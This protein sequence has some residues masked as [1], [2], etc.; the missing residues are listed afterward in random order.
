MSVQKKGIS[1]YSSRTQT[2]HDINRL[3]DIGLT[4]DQ[5]EPLTYCTQNK[6]RKKNSRY[7]HFNTGKKQY[8]GRRGK[9]TSTYTQKALNV[10]TGATASIGTNVPAGP[11]EPTKSAVQ[12]ENNP[13]NVENFQSPRKCAFSSSTSLS[14]DDP[15]GNTTTRNEKVLLSSIVISPPLIKSYSPNY[16]MWTSP[17]VFNEDTLYYVLYHSQKKV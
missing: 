3:L 5:L 7:Q 11:T 14:R 6:N 2:L 9:G 13:P 15:S 16:S 10:P 17:R 1:N 8:R 12:K 4:A